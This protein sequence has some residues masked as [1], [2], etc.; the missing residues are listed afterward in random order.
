MKKMQQG[1]TLIELMI[2]VAIIGIIAAV[3]IPQY[4]TYVAKSQVTRV[5]QEVAAIKTAIEGC[6]LEGRL[7]TGDPSDITKCDAQATGSTLQATSENTTA[8]GT[9]L[10]PATGTPAVTFAADATGDTTLV[11]KFGNSAAQALLG[12]TVTWTRNSGGSWT[13]KT[14]V[15]AKYTSPSCP[16]G[17]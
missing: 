3:A 4:Q 7:A 2:V 5:V 6:I 15:E 8:F 13:C 16:K 12:K 10:P 9:T 17:T 14:N 1:F 11:A